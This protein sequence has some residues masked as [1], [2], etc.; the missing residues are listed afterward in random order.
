MNETLYMRKFTQ[1]IACLQREG[2]RQT[3]RQ[4][5]AERY[6]QRQRG[7]ERLTETEKQTE[8]DR[9]TDRQNNSQTD[10]R[11]DRQRKYKGHRTSVHI[12]TTRL[13]LPLQ[14]DVQVL[15]IFV[16]F[17]DSVGE[18]KVK[19]WLSFSSMSLKVCNFSQIIQSVVSLSKMSPKCS[20][21]FQ[22]KKQNPTL[23]QNLLKHTVPFNRNGES[24]FTRNLVTRVSS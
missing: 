1:N 17:S 10:R 3:D 18:K 14:F 13:G 7:R 2:D 15:H 6:R 23:T 22:N 9:E 8:G 12:E 19:I 4:R 24:D 11:T 16:L 20:L 5:Q 21:A